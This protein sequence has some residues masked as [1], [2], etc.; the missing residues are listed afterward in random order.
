[1]VVIATGFIPLSPLSYV[2]I[3]VMWERSQWLGKNIVR[4]KE[5]QESMDRRRDITE[6]LLKRR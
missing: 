3:M 1:M 4:L 2:S 5:L 6:I